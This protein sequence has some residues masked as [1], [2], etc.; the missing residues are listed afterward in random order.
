MARFGPFI[1]LLFLPL[2][3]LPPAWGQGKDLLLRVLLQEVPQGQ[4]VRL[5]LPSGE[6]RAI[7]TGEGVVLGGRLQPSFDLDVPYFA[8]EGRPYRGGVRLLAQGGKLLV[9]NLVLLED[10]LLG[11]LPGEMPEGFPPEALKAQAVLARTFAV[12]RLNPK[13]PYDL[14]ASELCQVYLGFAAEKPRYAQAVAATRGQVLSFGGKAISALYHADSGGMTAGSEEVFQVALPYLRPR[15]DP[16]ARGP[17]SAWR[18]AVPKERAEKALRSL[19]YTPRGEE[20]P[21]V[22]ERTPSGRAWRVRLLGVEV[23]GPEAGRLLRLMGLPSALAEFQGFEAVGRGAGH[24]VG[25][26][27]W[28]AK[29]MAEAGFD[30]REILGHYFPGTFLSELLLAGVP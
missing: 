18:V 2:L 25:L 6:V 13:A 23:Q 17:K 4:G 15:P 29:G 19:G 28:G 14:C 30:H 21:Q 27:Q 26:S 9:V 3:A 16:Y 20:A 24:G 12:N 1:L 22:L 10:Y 8:L 11:V 7:A 5:S